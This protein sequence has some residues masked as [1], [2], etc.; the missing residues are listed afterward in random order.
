[1][2]VCHSDGE[3]AR[4][5]NVSAF[6]QG[7][8]VGARRTVL[9]GFSHSTVSRVYQEWSTARKISSQL[10]T[11]MGRIRVNMGQHTLEHFQ[12]LVESMSR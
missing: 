11:T 5:K 9:L 8:E 4:Q 3:W 7:M 6:E 12:H 10:D 1:M 2:Y